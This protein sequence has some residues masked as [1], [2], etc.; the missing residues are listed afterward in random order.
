MINNYIS[1]TL[2]A[3]L[4][5]L[6]S[7]C[8]NNKKSNDWLLLLLL[9]QNK[10]D[11]TQ[12][13]SAGPT[14][15]NDSNPETDPEPI[16]ETGPENVTLF[17]AVSA[18]A[19][20]SLSWKN[21]GEYFAGVRI[22]RKEGS[23][24]AHINDGTILYMGADESR[25][26]ST[27][28]NGTEYFYT[29]FS[30]D[31]AL[32][33]SSGVQANA[34]PEAIKAMVSA[35]GWHSCALFDT[36]KVRCWGEAFSGQLGY[37]NRTNIGDTEKPNSVEYVDI[38]GT[39]KQIEAGARHTCA[40]LTTGSVRCWGSSTDGQL[41]YGNKNQVGSGN[42]WTITAVG[43]VNVGGVVKQIAVGDYHTCALLTTGKVRCWGGRK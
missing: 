43:D 9:L 2:I 3:L 38:G 40:L 26:D 32:N 16:P 19:Q 27:V 20:V 30:Y 21:P 12:T 23:Y 33:Y 39:V 10:A 4:I 15:P 7:N 41:G 8:T 29:V 34:T 25:L 24:P 1:I 35:G 37:G 28:S 42:T 13:T 11:V 14:N 17:T 22:I 5:S 31:A 18:Q 36:G 6:L